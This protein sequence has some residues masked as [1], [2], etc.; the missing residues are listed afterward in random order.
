MSDFTGADLAPSAI[1]A[2][3]ERLRVATQRV[4]DLER[5]VDV[6]QRELETARVA[7]T[8]LRVSVQWRDLMT[9][10]NDD[11]A[12]CAVAERLTDAFAAFRQSLVEPEGYRREQREEAVDDQHIVAYSDTDDYADFSVVEAAV[13]EVLAAAKDQLE[14]HA[15]TPLPSSR[16]S[17]L[18]SPCESVVLSGKPGQHTPSTSAD[19]LR[20]AAVARHQALLQLLVITVLVGKAEHHC[21]FDS[22]RDS[23]NAPQSDAEEMREGVVAVWQWLFHDQPGVLT[24]EEGAEWRHIVETYLG[25]SYTAAP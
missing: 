7:C 23:S 2:E 6:L 9:S 3:R 13:E 10:V 1:A 24:A 11:E 8:Q 5:Q 16:H 25:A 19:V 12:V 20:A 15:A 18:A 21:Q 14:A 17:R 22:I 4:A